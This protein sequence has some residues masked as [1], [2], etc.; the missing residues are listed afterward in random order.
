MPSLIAVAGTLLGSALTFVFQNRSAARGERFNRD[1][2]LR[3]ERLSAYNDFVSAVTQLRQAV[4]TLWFRRRQEAEDG[5]PTERSWAAHLDSDRLGAVADH[6]KFRVKLVTADPA[7]ADLV[8]T[9]FPPI[10]AI[11]DAN[12]RA[13]VQALEA[14]SQELLS[15]FIAAARADLGH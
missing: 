9:V 2:R 7:L 6:A 8:E 4:I 12:D 10:S 11:I 3:A 15:A 14:R 5:E 13:Q 1:E